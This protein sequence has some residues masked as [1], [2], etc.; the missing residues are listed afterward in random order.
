V[1]LLGVGHYAGDQVPEQVNA[2][3]LAQP[4]LSG[5][6]MG[7]AFRE[8]TTLVTRRLVAFVP[9][10]GAALPTAAQAAEWDS[11]GQLCREL[12]TIT[13]QFLSWP[14]QPNQRPKTG[15]SP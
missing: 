4:G 2:L 9:F 12:C 8:V 10:L 15:Q 7:L 14:P 13:H 3:M 5:G 11:F 6:D 1:A